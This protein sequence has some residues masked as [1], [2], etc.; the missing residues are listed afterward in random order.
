MTPPPLAVRNANQSFS[1]RPVLR[2]CSFE[3]RPGA[4]TA[5]LGL[6][7]AGKTTIM[8]AVVGLRA[9]DSGSIL[10]DGEP[11]RAGRMHPSIGYLA[12]DKPLYRHFRVK[13]MLDFGRSMNDQWDNAR[14]HAI[15]DAAGL[16]PRARV[17]TLSGGHRTLLALALVLARRPKLLILDEPL[18]ALDPLARLEVQR[19]LMTE[20]VERGVSILLSSHVVPEVADMCDDIL[21]LTDGQIAIEGGIEE[22][23]ASHHH[24]TGPPTAPNNMSALGRV[25]YT[26]PG[27]RQ[28][29]FLVADL[30]RSTLPE[31]W[32]AE[33]VD[34]EEIVIGY[35]RPHQKDP[36]P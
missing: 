24:L 33:P 16:N 6:N 8:E 11:V 36:Q 3:L 26:T 5:L 21:V 23:I 31:G 18:A 27:E 30:E 4:V 14:A 15:V 17:A 9:L 34:L 1:G 10:I 20:V 12:Q 13:D 25:I 35:L 29:T 19:L 32:T 22:V 2:D 28:S 7:G